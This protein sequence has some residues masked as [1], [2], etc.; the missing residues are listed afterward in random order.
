MPSLHNL[1][2]NNPIFKLIPH[3][4]F[5]FVKF[6]QDRVSERISKYDPSNTSR[7]DLLSH[8]LEARKSYPD[9]VTDNEV[10]VYTLTNVIASSLSTSHVMDEIVKF[11]AAHPDAQQRVADEIKAVKQDDKLPDKFGHGEEISI[12]RSGRP[13]R[14]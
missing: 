10:F 9:I 2:A 7:P 5:D 4:T 14:L 1:L 11:L 6:A 12:C 3:Q 8:L 13:G